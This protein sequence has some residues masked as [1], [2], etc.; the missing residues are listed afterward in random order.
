M[1]WRTLLWKR[2][3]MCGCD[4]CSRK[5][6]FYYH[7]FF[8]YEHMPPAVVASQRSLSGHNHTSFRPRG[9]RDTPGHHIQ[10]PYYI[11]LH[12]LSLC[13]S[14]AEM[15]EQPQQ[16]E[17]ARRAAARKAKILA[18]GNA[19]LNKLAQSA[20]G[21]EAQK[22][23][24]DSRQSPTSIRLSLADSRSQPIPLQTSLLRVLKKSPSSPNGLPSLPLPPH[25][26]HNRRCLPTKPPWLVNLKP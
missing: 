26:P 20:R 22:L 8:G 25:A 24:P 12:S 7:L 19:G 14:S 5:D 4:R 2:C 21:E 15:S 10:A 11:L 13:R 17:A 9:D 16:S 3:G 18:R 6:I 23:Y 1:E